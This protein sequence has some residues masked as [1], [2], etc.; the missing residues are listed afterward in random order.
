L[1]EYYACG[2]ESEH[3]AHFDADSEG[4]DLAAELPLAELEA[5]YGGEEGECDEAVVEEAE[6]EYTM[7]SLGKDEHGEEVGRCLDGPR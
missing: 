6:E 7:Q 5:V 4:E 3:E 1:D 2:W